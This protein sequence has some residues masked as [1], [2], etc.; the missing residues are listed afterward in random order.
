M[1][2]AQQF[3]MRNARELVLWRYRA[4]GPPRLAPVIDSKTFDHIQKHWKGWFQ[5]KKCSLPIKDG[6][7][8]LLNQ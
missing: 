4:A 1:F 6:R 2:F 7:K 3:E 5:R 8:Q